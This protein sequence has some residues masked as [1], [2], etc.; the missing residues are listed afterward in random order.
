M[1]IFLLIFIYLEIVSCRN[2]D[3][4]S[5][6]QLSEYKPSF[7]KEE[8]KPST[9]S[10]YVSMEYLPNFHHQIT[11]KVFLSEINHDTFYSDEFIFDDFKH[12]KEEI[13][14]YIKNNNSLWNDWSLYYQGDNRIL[15]IDS[16]NKN[17]KFRVKYQI[18]SKYSTSK[19]SDIKI[20]TLQHKNNKVNIYIKGTGRN[21]HENAEVFLNSINIFKH[22][23]YQGLAG[24][25]LNRKD[26]SVDKVKFF[27]TFNKKITS[28]NINEDFI[29]Y[30]YD[31]D[32]NV[33]KTTSK[34]E[35]SKD[36]ILSVSQ[37]FEKFLKNTKM[38]Q[39]L[40]I[41]SC[42]GWEKYFTYH[43]A[44]ILGNFGALKI[45]ELSKSFYYDKSENDINEDNIL[46]KN[47]YFHPY[48]FMGIK[49]IGQGNGYEVVQSNKGYYLT[50]EGLIPA[51]IIVTMKYNK[52]NNAY[53][54]DREQKFQYLNN[55]INYKYLYQSYDFSLK[56]L[57]PFLITANQTTK[58]NLHFNIY[59]ENKNEIIMQSRDSLNDINK[60]YQTEL[61]R[62][63]LGDNIGGLR[64]KYNGE[65]YQ[66][67]K[68]IQDLEYYNFY[69][70][71]IEGKECAPP[72]TQNDEECISPDVIKH[73]QYDI[74]LIMCKIGVQPQICENN[75]D[76]IYNDFDGFD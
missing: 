42:Y 18:I 21:N 29:N 66:N 8:I 46:G 40:I 72:Y 30:S 13:E 2:I 28:N 22:G 53:F 69:K 65:I 20:I 47:L 60:V 74:P 6:L 37:D 10:F 68:N 73:Y 11:Y 16:S 25:L 17:S 51:E 55:L 9:N 57:F 56:N 36:N 63:V 54:F 59:S 7:L 14:L 3:K 1:S 5:F 12:T 50:T 4:N 70:A 27:D 61:D 76:Y 23:K 39:L 44:E 24:I 43:S 41:V 35:I 38:S 58:N 34:K 32:G 26:L 67:G 31:E 49:N 45:K 48:A 71:V 15:K 33:I 52:Y 75:Q 62:I 64:T 19:E